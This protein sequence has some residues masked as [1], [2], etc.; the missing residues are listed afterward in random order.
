MSVEAEQG[1]VDVGGRAGV[2]LGS[3][4]KKAAIAAV[5]VLLLCIPMVAFRTADAVGGLELIPRWGMV[6]TLVVVAFIGQFLWGV[7][8]ESANVAA[9][10]GQVMAPVGNAFG[11]MVP[12]FGAALIGFAVVLPFLPIADR[13]IM[14]LAILVVTYVMLGWG[15]NIVVG[16]AGL[17]DL[18]YVAFYAVGAYSY[19]LLAEHFRLL[20]LDLPAA[21]RY[22][23]GVLGHHSWLPGAAAQRRLSRDRDAGLRR[24]HP[25][26]AAQLV[27]VHG[28]AGRAVVNPAAGFL[29]ARIQAVR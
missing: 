7:L 18:G 23:G 14:D 27:R 24:D 15:L 4:L 19:A 1:H 6:A 22:P 10:T 26:R 21:C 12:F 28:R 3:H 20:V 2:S 17:L 13:Y 16:L 9:A 8:R 11:Q 5:V 25:H 29:R